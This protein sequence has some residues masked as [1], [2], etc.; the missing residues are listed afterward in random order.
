MVYYIIMLKNCD[1]VCGHIYPMLDAG[2][3]ST[4]NLGERAQP[5]VRY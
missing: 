3:C 5:C 2:I 4:T 1:A